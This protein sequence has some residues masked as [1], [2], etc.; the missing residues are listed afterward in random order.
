[1]TFLPKSR[2]AR[3]RLAIIAMATPILVAATALTLYGLRGSISYFYTPSQAANAHVPPGRSIELGGLVVVGS[4][5]RGPNGGVFFFMR[6][7][8]DRSL[9]S[10]K[11]A[12]PDLF[13]EGQGVVASGAYD[14]R[15]VF[16][17]TQILAKHD[18]RYMPRELTRAL[19]AS[20]E[21]R[22]GQGANGRS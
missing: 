8:T 1:M 4:V 2:S 6:D 16:I 12:L 14:A 10:Y 5:T 9:V 21:W 17:A 7:H 18:E 20:G 13:R 3:R 22:P 19:R 11:G 15:G